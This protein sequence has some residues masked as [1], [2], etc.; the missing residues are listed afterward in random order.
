M[1][2]F[3]IAFY[4]F[5]LSTRKGDGCVTVCVWGGGG[6]TDISVKESGPPPPSPPGYRV[7]PPGILKTRTDH[8]HTE[9]HLA[10]YTPPCAGD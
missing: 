8:T 5:Y 9:S 10:G 3:C 6:E 2:T 4:E 7:P 1:T